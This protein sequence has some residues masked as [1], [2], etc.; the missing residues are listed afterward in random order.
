MKVDASLLVEKAQKGVGAEIS[1]EL[2]GIAIG[3]CVSKEASID[4]LTSGK[5]F[6]KCSNINDLTVARTS[7]T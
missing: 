3:A 1:W 6:P 2:T 7:Y 5:L 4:T